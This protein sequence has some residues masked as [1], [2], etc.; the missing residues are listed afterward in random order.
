MRLVDPDALGEFEDSRKQDEQSAH[1][2]EIAARARAA[3]DKVLELKRQAHKHH[4]FLSN[5]I[6]HALQQ[7]AQALDREIEEHQGPAPLGVLFPAVFIPLDPKQ[8]PVQPELTLP[9]LQ[10]WQEKLK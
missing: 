7:K 1:Q 6:G 5:A 2:Q 4:N 8:P 9:T 3:R 10:E